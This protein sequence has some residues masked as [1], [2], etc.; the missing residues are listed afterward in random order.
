M[1]N[2]FSY[3]ASQLLGT[4]FETFSMSTDGKHYSWEPNSVVKLACTVTLPVRSVSK[5]LF[6]LF[7]KV[8]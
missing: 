6:S 2:A 3:A 1:D 4:Q 7:V 8:A 5:F